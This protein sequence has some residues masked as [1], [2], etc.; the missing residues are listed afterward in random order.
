ML[1]QVNCYW[2]WMNHSEID[3]KSVHFFVY[4]SLLNFD[5]NYLNIFYSFCS[6]L[7]MLLS[8]ADIQVE[9]EIIKNSSHFILPV[10][11]KFVGF[12]WV[13]SFGSLYSIGR[14]IELD[15]ENNLKR[16]WN[17]IQIKKIVWM[18]NTS[19]TFMEICWM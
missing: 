18:E 6:L 13:S 12:K 3:F 8:P 10:C 14:Y 2:Q 16:L 9:L 4:V 15:H 19:Q 7:P 5:W 11:Q 17:C 1:P